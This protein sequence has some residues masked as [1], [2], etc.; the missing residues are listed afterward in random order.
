MTLESDTEE[1][2][3][4]RKRGAPK[5]NRNAWKHG[6]RS[7]AAK[8]ERAAIRGRRV[9][10]L[11]DA[12]VL[13]PSL[14]HVDW[15]YAQIEAG[16]RRAQNSPNK[17]N[18]SVWPA[19][20]GEGCTNFS[21]NKTNNSVSAAREGDPPPHFSP[22]KTNN[23]DLTG[24]SPA[25]RGRGTTQRET[26]ASAFAKGVVE[27]AKPELRFAPLPAYGGT[28]PASQGES[29][30]SVA[31]EPPRRRG[32]PKGN[33]NALKHGMKSAERLAFKSDLRKFLR[34]IHATCGLAHA[35][36]KSRSSSKGVP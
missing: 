5:G 24:S 30:N 11:P 17:T 22:N 18:N 28:L 8:A 25:Q 16:A 14:A 34:R 26:R 6:A 9:A 21:P 12:R 27:G 7:A 32:A 23:S 31:D 10:S 19:V 3:A 1:T 13:Q 29:H 4:P 35:I 15:A 2:N 36:A 20:E 33:K